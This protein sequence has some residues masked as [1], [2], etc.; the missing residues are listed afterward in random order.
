MKTGDVARAPVPFSI[1]SLIILYIH[2][3]L[4]LKICMILKL[5]FI[6]QGIYAFILQIHIY[7]HYTI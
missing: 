1:K 7:V 4:K 5:V 2:I 3:N 6:Y